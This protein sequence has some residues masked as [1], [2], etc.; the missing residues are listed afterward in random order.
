MRFKI[1]VETIDNDDIDE[2]SGS[3][4]DHLEKLDPD[5]DPQPSLPHSKFN[6]S[7]QYILARERKFMHAAEENTKALYFKDVQLMS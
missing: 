6:I 2:G 1:W 7:K 5:P 4:S 3:G